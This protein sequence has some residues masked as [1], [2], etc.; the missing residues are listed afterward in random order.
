MP[1]C[2]LRSELRS[3][4]PAIEAAGRQ[5][6]KLK[7]AT[8]EGFEDCME[9][10]ANLDNFKPFS[11]IFLDSLSHLMNISL[12]DE[13][14][15]EKTE[16]TDVK[17]PLHVKGK[18]TLPDQ[19]A[20]N[21]NIF[22]L[23]NALM[24][25]AVTEGKVVVV[26]CRIKENPKYRPDLIGAPNLMGR[27]VPDNFGGF[28]DLIGILKSNKDDDG[29][30]IYPPYVSF[31]DSEYLTKYTGVGRTSGLYNLEKI[32]NSNGKGGNNKN[33]SDSEEK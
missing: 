11:T 3:I 13:I 6:L 4:K 31:R 10:C 17:Q 8:Y 5:D 16:D 21:R 32:L 30:I 1:I 22:R 18:V 20:L 14:V 7:I 33:N 9:F 24:R 15:S 27:E 28:F 25:I 29:N 26:S 2:Y 23:L 19:G 12:A